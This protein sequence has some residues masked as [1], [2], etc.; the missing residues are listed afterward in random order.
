[1]LKDF[2]QIESTQVTVLYLVNKKIAIVDSIT[3]LN[4]G[5]QA[6]VIFARSPLFTIFIGLIPF[7]F[8]ID[9]FRQA[10]GTGEQRGA[11]EIIS[12]IYLVKMIF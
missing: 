2:Q 10:P 3:K 4:M 9:T 5:L 7:H 11:G 12:I 8:K 1:L 6:D